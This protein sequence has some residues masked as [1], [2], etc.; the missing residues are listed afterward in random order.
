MRPLHYTDGCNLTSSGRSIDGRKCKQSFQ[1]SLECSS[2][3]HDLQ[4]CRKTI[5]DSRCSDRESGKAYCKHLQLTSPQRCIGTFSFPH[6]SIPPCVTFIPHVTFLLLL[7]S[8]IFPSLL[9]HCFT[10]PIPYTSHGV[11]K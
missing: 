2:R 5:P 7:H 4:L 11:S 1:M 9:S 6:S 8:H 10:P 3:S